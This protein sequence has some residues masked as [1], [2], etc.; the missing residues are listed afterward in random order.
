M[1]MNV[2]PI[3]TLNERVNEIRQLTASIV[4]KEI[5]PNENFLW[6]WRRGG[7][8]IIPVPRPRVME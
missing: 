4:N 2:H 1:R 7:R 3:P 6:I 5:L 8:F